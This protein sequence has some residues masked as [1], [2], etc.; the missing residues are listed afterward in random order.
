M[1]S[2]CTLNVTLK[3]RVGYG[4]FCCEMEKTETYYATAQL[5]RA[6]R[7]YTFIL[8]DQAFITMFPI[9]R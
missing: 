6:K 7:K 1:K 8:S 5:N 3:G 9:H 4:L 2:K